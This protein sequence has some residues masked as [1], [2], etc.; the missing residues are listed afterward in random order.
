MTN[1]IK[2]KFSKDIM[3]CWDKREIGQL[4][5]LHSSVNIPL[6][7]EAKMMHDKGL[8]A[9]IVEARI[10]NKEFPE[11]GSCIARQVFTDKTLDSASL[12]IILAQVFHGL[13]DD[14]INAF[15]E[16]KLIKGIRND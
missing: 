8:G 7:I 9:F 4:D 14:I 2:T 16:K 1:A 3:E 5:H 12:S 10:K 11:D 6:T 13:Y 15:I